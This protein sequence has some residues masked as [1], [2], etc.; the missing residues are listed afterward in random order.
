MSAG[1][2][3][4]LGQRK[5]NAKKCDGRGGIKISLIFCLNKCLGEYFYECDQIYDDCRR[6]GDCR[7]V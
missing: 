7:W 3:V 1:Q 6:H 5:V 4:E 2:V